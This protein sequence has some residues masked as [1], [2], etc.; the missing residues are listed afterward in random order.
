MLSSSSGGFGDGVVDTAARSGWS[1]I[2][3]MASSVPPIV[4]TK[5]MRPRTR[6]RKRRTFIDARDPLRRVDPVDPAAARKDVQVA[7]GALPEGRKLRH[8]GTEEAVV[9]RAASVL[10]ERAQPSDAV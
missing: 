9:L 4:A 5:A 3:G 6:P 10:D 2:A 7:V 8:L 1:N